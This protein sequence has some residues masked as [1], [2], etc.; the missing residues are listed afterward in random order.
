MAVNINIPSEVTQT[1][2][3][4]VTTTAPSENAVFDAL[5]LKANSADLA[6]VATSGDYNDLDNL[7]TLNNGTVTSVDLTMPPAFSVSGNPV[8]SSGTLA[9]AAAGLSSQYIRG[10]GQLANFPTSSGGGSS[11]NFYLNGSVAQGTLGGVAFKQMSSTPVIGAG[12]DFTINADGYIQSFITDAS[13]PNQL[14]IPGGNWNF[15][16]YFSASSNGGTPRFYLELYKLSGGTLTLLASSSATPEFIT[17]GTQ[18]DLYTTALAV[19]STVLLAADRLA[20]R[21][22]VIHSS[23]TITL[24]TENSHLCQ[25]ITTFSTGLTALNGLTSQVQNLAVGTSGTDFAISSATNTHTFNLPTASASNR[26]ALST[27]DWSAF[28]GKQAALVS[29]TN[30]KSING[31]SLLGAGDLVI[32]GGGGITVGTT[33]VTSGTIGRVFFQATGDVVQQSANLFWDNTN[34]RL[35]LGAVASNTA[36]LDIK[37]PGALSTSIAFRVRNSID[38][39]NLMSIAGDGRVAIGL[40]A[41]I[42]GTTDAF[43]NV[44][45]GGGAKDIPTAGVTENAVAFGYNA[46]SNNGGTAIGANTSITGIQG[47][48]IGASA[49]AGLGCTAIGHSARADGTSGYQSLAIG[50]GARASALLSGIIAVGQSSYTNALGQTLAF[51]VDPSGANSQT[52]LLTNKAN[53]VFRNSTQLT[54]GTHWNVAATN[55]LTIHNGVIPDTTIANAGQLYVEGGALKFRGGSG[56]ITVV[57]PA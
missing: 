16:M 14:L 25:V 9:V 17:N 42:L 33:A 37:A 39:Q 34:G 5:A 46:V 30:I 2:T 26:G 6:L 28:N 7:P 1:I 19:P 56:T 55:T 18:I 52:M 47:V 4:G 38:S 50:Y 24:H 53:L 57:A 54:S 27:S 23:K 31:N 44:V 41:Q 43:K 40:N 36:T 15:E 20:V 11:V 3:D 48:A 45:I 22:Y 51:C 32:S 29:G 21:V 49:I 13:V 10:D 8:T 35:N 12:T